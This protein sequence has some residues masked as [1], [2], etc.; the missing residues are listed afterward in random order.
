VEKVRRPVQRID[1]PDQLAARRP[2]GRQL[3]AH[4]DRVRLL[5]ADHFRDDRFGR[6]VDLG[7]EVVLRFLSPSLYS[8]AGSAPQIVGG[9]Q[10]SALSQLD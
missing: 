7:H 6:A 3:L 5:A 1:D 8:G 4:D 10:R 9:A 2:L